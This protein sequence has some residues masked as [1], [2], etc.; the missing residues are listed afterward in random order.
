[1]PNKVIANG[2]PVNRE[3]EYSA[4]RLPIRVGFN[5]RQLTLLEQT[6]ILRLLLLLDQRE[7]HI[8]EL[9]RTSVNPKGIGSQTAVDNCRR[10]L[11]E[12]ELAKEWT[13]EVTPFKTLL[14]IT[15]KGR[16][17]AQKIREIEAI[18]ES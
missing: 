16:L 17:V 14:I 15:E 13:E 2:F 8:A 7:H 18:L 1:M 5:M 4:Y 6:G 11:A 9:K 12:L 10:K 3:N